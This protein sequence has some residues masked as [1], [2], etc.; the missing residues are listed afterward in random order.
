M[1]GANVSLD[2]C[3]AE[4]IH[5]NQNGDFILKVDIDVLRERLLTIIDE[6]K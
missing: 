2:K 3:L 5:L 4:M 1:I 6:G